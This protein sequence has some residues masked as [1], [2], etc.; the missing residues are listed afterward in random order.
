M[1]K[2]IYEGFF[3]TGDQ[4]GA[5]IGTLSR[6]VMHKHITTEFN[7]PVI[8]NDLY[9]IAARFTI[10]GYGNDGDNEAFSVELKECE[11]EELVKIVNAIEVP[12]ITLSVSDTGF[13]LNSK[14]LNFGGN[15]VPTRK[16]RIYTVNTIFGGFLT[17]SSHINGGYPVID[18]MLK[19]P[20]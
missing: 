9:G 19:L 13:P 12:H 10:T 16:A 2:I 1:S 15:Y 14:N 3:I 17:E 5:S 6:K 7:P 8:H 4:I 20:L 11:N 18:P